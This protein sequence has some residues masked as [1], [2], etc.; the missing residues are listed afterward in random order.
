MALDSRTL[1]KS[2]REQGFDIRRTKQGWRVQKAGNK[3]Y[4]FHESTVDKANGSFRKQLNLLADLKKHGFTDPSEWEKQ[5][6]Q[7]LDADP[8][9]GVFPCPHHAECGKGPFPYARNLANHLKHSHNEVYENGHEKPAA[10]PEPAPPPPKVEPK[11]SRTT[12]RPAASPVVV[13]HTDPAPPTDPAE[14]EKWHF[15]RI[16]QGIGSFEWLLKQV[17][18]IRAERDEFKRKY[19]RLAELLADAVDEL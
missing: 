7:G 3:P 12:G 18:T 17:V 11:M 5:A 2:L 8:S 19:E 1:I 9:R 6:K 10:E 15:T 14:L 13:K 4:F 16:Q